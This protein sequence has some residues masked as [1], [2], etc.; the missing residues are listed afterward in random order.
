MKSKYYF[1]NPIDGLLKL[2]ILIY[3]NP[4]NQQ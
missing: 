3:I 2:R 4:Q 1:N